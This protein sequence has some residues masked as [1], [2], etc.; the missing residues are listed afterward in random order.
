MPRLKTSGVALFGLA[1][2]LAPLGLAADEMV[3][4]TSGGASNGTESAGQSPSKAKSGKDL[5]FIIDAP[6]LRKV[7]KDL[8]GPRFTTLIGQEVYSNSGK[9]IG[10]IEDFVMAS[11]GEIYA[12]IDSSDGPIEKL[13]KM[14]DGE[15]L[16]L[17]LRE[18]RKAALPGEKRR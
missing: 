11:R 4:G 10:K 7:G 2:A 3:S 14:G 8:A 15:M 13:V 12:V 1:I 16:I 6:D 18:L 17:P 5:V 9:K